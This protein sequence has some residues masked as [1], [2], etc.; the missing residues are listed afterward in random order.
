[1]RARWPG[2]QL[3]TL[4]IDPVEVQEGRVIFEMTPAEWHYNPIGRVHG[5]VLA[6]L[7]DT[8]LGCAVHSCPPEPAT[9]RW[10]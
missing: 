10:K 3:D 1:V 2:R 5:G 6:T 7:A 4:A 8:A 9:Q